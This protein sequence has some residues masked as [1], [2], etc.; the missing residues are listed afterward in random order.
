MFGKICCIL[1]S[2]YDKLIKDD[3][4]GVMIKVNLENVQNN[5]SYLQNLQSKNIIAVVKENAYNFG[6][7]KMVNIC[8]QSGIRDFMVADFMEL[9]NFPRYE[10]INLMVGNTINP[11]NLSKIDEKVHLFISSYQYLVD[12]HKKIKK[13]P[14]HIK[15]NSS[16]NRFGIKEI[17]EIILAIKFCKVNKLNLV[18]ICTHFA[19]AE[20]DQNLHDLHIN[21]FIT[22]ID[23]VS[24]L[25]DFKYIHSENSAAFLSSNPKLSFC[26][27]ARIGIA[28]YGYSIKEYR[29][30]L[31]QGLDVLADVVRV[32][33]VQKN[34]TIGYGS[35]YRL[36]KDTL[37]AIVNMGYG[38]G[39]DQ[40]F[41]R[42]SVL[43]K[44]KRYNL[45]AN[46]SMSH[47]YVEVDD[48]VKVGDQVVLFDHENRLD[49]LE[50]LINVTNRVTICNLKVE[51]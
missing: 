37:I 1:F 44:N 20:L 26:T 28:L 21:N 43:I 46:I 5:I 48:D 4:R 50:D 49:D 25:H 34:E 2:I 13:N 42:M 8:I 41:N 9:E 6:I 27:H 15:F 47:F 40:R 14:L 45:I 3:T 11:M 29:K 12:N 33:N 17:E 23:K 22:V 38:S 24:K 16:L 10:N 18:G 31:L 19:E 32:Q 7:D 36:E 35:S 30:N 39:L 51:E